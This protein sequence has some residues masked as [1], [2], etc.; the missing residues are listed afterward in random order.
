L[1]DPGTPA[2]PRFLPEYDNLVLSHSDRSRVFNDLGPGGPFP[3]N[4]AVG[5][6]LVDGFYR[7]N[8]ALGEEDGMATLIIDR[9]VPHPGEGS[10]TVDEIAAESAGLLA[11]LAPDAAERR[12]EFVPSP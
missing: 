6:L 8:W 5:A 1:P 3:V 2:P 11:F 12:V 9:F 10:D 4:T 7:A